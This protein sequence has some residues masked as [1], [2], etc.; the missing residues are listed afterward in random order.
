MIET[1]EVLLSN[2]E[3]AIENW[4]L[5]PAVVDQPDDPYWVKA[6][7]IFGTSVHEAKRR[8]CCNCEYYENTPEKLAELEAIPLNKYD[9]YNSTYH[10]GYCH[11]LRII[12]HTTRSCQ[13]WEEKDYEV[14]DDARP[15]PGGALYPSMNT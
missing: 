7:Q 14:P 1:P 11:K 6:A 15:F 4:N 2:T 10:R 12:C 5:G 8:I 9:I 3:K 13:A